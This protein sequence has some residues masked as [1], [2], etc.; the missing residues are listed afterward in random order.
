M[1][2]LSTRAALVTSFLSDPN[3]DTVWVTPSDRT[4]AWGEKVSVV[5]NCFDP[6]GETEGDGTYGYSAQGVRMSNLDDL[7][8]WALVAEAY[9][10]QER[11]NQAAEYVAARVTAREAG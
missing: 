2:L 11:F 6:T 5:I 8:V 4:P 1:S 9:R 3:L 10:Q 7:A